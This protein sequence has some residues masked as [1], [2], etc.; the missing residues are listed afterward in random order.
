MWGLE[1]AD[2]QLSH[3]ASDTPNELATRWVDDLNEC[4]EVAHDPP[5]GALDHQRN[6]VGLP[7]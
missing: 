5:E 4:I 6:L 7:H 2:L 3:F 1:S